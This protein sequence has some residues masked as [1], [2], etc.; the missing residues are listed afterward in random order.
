MM[1]FQALEC[2]IF[3]AFLGGCHVHNF[4]LRRAFWASWYQVNVGNGL[5]SAFEFS[6]RCSLSQA[7]A[8]PNSQPTTPDQRS[9]P[10]VDIKLSRS[11]MF[12]K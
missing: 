5:D 1:A 10:V 11:V 6:H 9:L 8:L 2:P 4:H 12:P 3:K 7:G